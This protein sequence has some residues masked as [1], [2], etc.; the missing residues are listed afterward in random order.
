[1][2]ATTYNHIQSAPYLN[3]A[4]LGADIGNLLVLAPHPDD[5]SLGCGGLIKLIKNLGKK[6]YVVFITSGSAS[7]PNS[8]THPADVLAKTREAEALKAC[9]NLGLDSEN[10]HF[11]QQ[12][13][14]KLVQL[15][16]IALEK[17]SLEIYRIFEH[18][19]INTVAMPWRRDP[20]PDHI[21]THNLGDLILGKLGAEITK[22]EYPIWLWKNGKPADW[23]LNAEVKPYRLDITEVFNFKWNAIKAHRSQLGEIITD[24]RYGFVLTEELLEPFNSNTEYFFL[25]KRKNLETLAT[26]YFEDLYTEKIDPWNFRHSSYEQEKYKNTI[27]A[28]KPNRYANCLE[29]GCSIGIQTQLLSKICDHILAIDISPTAIAAARSYC[30]LDD[31]VTFLAGDITKMFPNGSYDLITCCEIGYYLNTEDLLTLFKNIDHQLLP[32]GKLLM[33]HWTP[34]VPDYPLT[35]DEV[36]DVFTELNE[37]WGHFEELVHERHETYRLQ[38]WK[39]VK[40]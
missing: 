9:Q 17:L 35:G 29:L 15:D 21:V 13:D 2:I 26:D 30:A 38:V 31:K 34:F 25:T 39:K 7:H 22:M 4:R 3:K 37:K 12:Q 6:V 18:K 16:T 40:N 36:H 32:N 5:E 10:L 20:H 28:L 27:V 33:V 19:S 24:D 14:G 23:P 1:M 8:K 11:I